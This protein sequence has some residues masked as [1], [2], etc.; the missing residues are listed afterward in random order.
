MILVL[1]LGHG[2]FHSV[3]AVLFLSKSVFGR[4]LN[5]FTAGNSFFPT[6]LLEFSLGRDLGALKGLRKVK[7]LLE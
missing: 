3:A 6:N 5:A 2:I 4:D 7:E 1:C